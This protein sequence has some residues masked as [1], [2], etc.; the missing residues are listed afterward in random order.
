MKNAIQVTTVLLLLAQS[1]GY[2]QSNTTI[3]VSETQ[4]T[5]LD[6]ETTKIENYTDAYTPFL[7]TFLLVE[8][9]FTLEIILEDNKPYIVTEFSK[10]ILIPTNETTLHE[11]TRGVDLELI[12]G[13]PDV[14]KFT[15]NGYETTIKRVNSNTEK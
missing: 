3:P 2:C 9:D 7:G 6:K 1:I 12:E 13:N 14:L 11:L 4:D 8:G 15:Q 5:T 10:D